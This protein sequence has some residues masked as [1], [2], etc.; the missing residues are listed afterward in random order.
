MKTPQRGDVVHLQFDPAAGSEMRG[1]HYGLVVSPGSFNAK[2]R[3]AWICPISQGASEQ[4]RSESFLITLMGTGCATQGSVHTHQI[5]ALDFV[6]R[7]AR[8]VERVPALVITEV[9][10]RLR[11]VLED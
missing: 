3:K 5:K 1:P 4:A 9:L 10:E 6:A 8:V 11:V 2:F 7:K